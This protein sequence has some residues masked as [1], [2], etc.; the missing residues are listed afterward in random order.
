MTGT[1]RVQAHD[2]HRL[3]LEFRSQLERAGRPVGRVRISGRADGWLHGHDCDRSFERLADIIDTWLKAGGEDPDP[4]TR[5]QRGHPVYDWPEVPEQ[6]DWVDVTSG[7]L[8]GDVGPRLR[9][10]AAQTSPH[11][12]AT[13]CGFKFVDEDIAEAGARY[14]R[15]T[16]CLRE[17]RLR[18][19]S[20]AP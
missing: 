5:C 7:S 2:L 15:C 18:E 3:L 1:V 9:H 13:V 14:K 12:H 19:R 8:A 6:M 17:Q 10:L 16:V 20:A 4:R 11:W